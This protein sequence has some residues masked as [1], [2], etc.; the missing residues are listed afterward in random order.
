MTHRIAPRRIAVLAVLSLTAL[1]ACGG[2]D[3]PAAS[4]DTVAAVPTSAAPATTAPSDPG[5]RAPTPIEYTS[6]AAGPNG[7][8]EMST[9]SDS[10]MATDMMIA[11]TYVAEFVVSPDLPALPTADTGYVYDGSTP[12]TAEQ[13]V[14]LAAL[15][16][17]SGQPVRVD[18]WE[19]GGW[20]VGPTDGSAPSLFLSDDAQHS[21][22]YSPAY[23]G[24]G[25]SGSV[26]CE[27]VVTSDPATSFVD[28]C[29]A[30]ATTAPAPPAGVPTADEA[31]ARATE[32]LGQLGVDPAGLTVEPYADEWS[33]SVSVSDPVLGRYWGFGFGAEGALQWANGTLATP[34][35]VGPYP[36]IDLDTALARLDE[37]TGMFLPVDVLARDA[38]DAATSDMVGTIEPDPASSVAVTLPEP[39]PVTVT[40]VG[41]QPDF[42]WA[43]DADNNVWLVPAYRFIGDDGAWYTVPAVADEYLVQVDPPAVEQ[44]TEPPVTSEPIATEPATTE[45]AGTAAETSLDGLIGSSLD[46]FTAQAEAD[47][48]TVRVS[49]IDGA[50]QPGTMDYRDNR[51]NVAVATGA[52]GTQTVTAILSIG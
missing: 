46:E 5:L 24:G 18:D 9:A 35:P 27:V 22:S 44:P 29:V 25:V 33:A 40:L 1:A 19:P 42:W 15:F 36:L 23:D 8:A 37:Q 11:P 2:D 3:E 17:V 34:E 28:D 31:V 38:A 10:R 16:G 45:P 43:W 51:V 41:V 52:D 26:G 7:T 14:E 20:Q 12:T 47:G 48:W 39:E 6:G 13:A 50:P 21:W 32:L 49:E 30:P 4:G